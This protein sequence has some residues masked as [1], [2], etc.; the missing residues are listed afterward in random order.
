MFY[1]LI[2]A[3]NLPIFP[4]N[5]QVT[6][7]PLDAYKIQS[8][9]HVKIASWPESARPNS[10]HDNRKTTALKGLRDRDLF[11]NTVLFLY[12]SKYSQCQ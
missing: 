10:T 8:Q 1:F 11:L 6:L 5:T 12:S 4:S 9:G 3:R 7:L 2:W